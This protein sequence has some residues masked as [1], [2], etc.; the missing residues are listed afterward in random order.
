LKDILQVGC[1]NVGAQLLA[2]IYRGANVGA[3]VSGRKCE[4]AN[5]RCAYV[6]DQKSPIHFFLF[7]KD[8][9]Q[10]Q[11]ATIFP[12]TTDTNYL[13]DYYKVCGNYPTPSRI[14]ILICLPMEM[15]NKILFHVSR[16]RAIDSSYKNYSYKGFFYKILR[17]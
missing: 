5:V 16:E 14:D 12:W 1:E 8:P 6:R 15:L 4:S 11:I 13:V 2:R 17:K 9:F 10:P 3:H 7:K